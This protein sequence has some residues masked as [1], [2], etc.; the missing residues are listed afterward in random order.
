[1]REYFDVLNAATVGAVEY[2]TCYNVGINL[3]TG[4]WL[5]RDVIGPCWLQK[6]NDAGTSLEL[7]YAASA[8]AG[9][10]PVW[11]LSNA[12]GAA[13]GTSLISGNT[14]IG[15]A[16]TDSHTVNG[17]TVRKSGVSGASVVNIVET[18]APASGAGGTGSNGAGHAL[19]SWTNNNK[20][21]DVAYIAARLQSGGTGGGASTDYAGYPALFSKAVGD[22][23]PQPRFFVNENG[24]G[25]LTGNGGTVTQPTNKG[26]AVTLNKP[27]GQITMN[28]AA[29]AA[30]ATSSFTLSSSAFANSDI[31]D[32]VLAGGV[33]SFGNYSARVAGMN[34]GGG[35]CIVELTNKS[36]GAL[37][38]AVVLNFQVR[39]GAIA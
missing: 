16:G 24:F 27:S 1:V 39:K 6:W 36:A 15:N 18:V 8:A 32:V 34:I 11:V 35:A 9:V 28:A 30:G 17:S 33:S 29:L 7:W 22:A 2:G 31:V 21:E 37:A 3:A 23:S 5:G 4:A 25:Y 38:E 10:A 26:A 20:A 12:F 13:N 19:R 14:T